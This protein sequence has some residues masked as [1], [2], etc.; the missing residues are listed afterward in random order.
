MIAACVLAMETI[1]CDISKADKPDPEG[2]FSPSRPWRRSMCYLWPSASA[3]ETS[4]T[5][6]LPIWYLTK[7]KIG[8]KRNFFLSMLYFCLTEECHSPLL[9]FLLAFC[10]GFSVSASSDIVGTYTR[11]TKNKHRQYSLSCKNFPLVYLS[12][13]LKK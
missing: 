2:Y 1:S 12:E 8:Q 11:V 13:K 4:Y 3:R 9:Y 10:R 7:E 5:Y 6:C